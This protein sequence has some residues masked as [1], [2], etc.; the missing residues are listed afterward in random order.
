MVSPC[1]WPVPSRGRPLV[2]AC[3]ETGGLA[4]R[5]TS[6]AHPTARRGSGSSFEKEEAPVGTPGLPNGR[7]PWG[8]GKMIALSTSTVVDRSQF[9]AGVCRR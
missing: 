6:P 5:L 3:P 2:T 9:L 7:S 4:E 1:T 8:E